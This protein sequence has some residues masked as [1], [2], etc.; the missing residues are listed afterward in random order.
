MESRLS[1]RN[2]SEVQ[3]QQ[4]S[5]AAPAPQMTLTNP[6]QTM[7]A[8]NPAIAREVAT[9]QAQMIIAQTCPRNIAVVQQ[10]IDTACSRLQLAAY[11]SYSYQR[12]GTDIN[13]PSIRLAEALLNAYGNSKAGFEI[14]AQTEK[15]STVRAYAFDMETNTLMER[16]FVVPHRRDT[17][18]GSKTLTDA[19]DIYEAVAN[20]AARRVRACILAIIPADLQEYAVQ[21]CNETVARNV[22]IT[23]DT[24]DNLLAAFS[25][26]GVSK[27]QIEAFIQRHLEA[28]TVTQYLR[29]RSMYTAL[30]DGLAKPE[31]MFA[32]IED[33][34]AIEESPVN[35]STG[36]SPVIPP[37]QPESTAE[38]KESA[39]ETK[40]MSDV[41]AEGHTGLG[42]HAEPEPDEPRGI[43]PAESAHGVYP[44]AEEV[45]DD[46]FNF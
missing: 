32:P 12:G 17:K 36:S 24:L 22:K 29:L 40:R 27:A 15:E 35:A 10:K 3:T 2:N 33:A 21:K 18:A 11:A 7:F 37:T 30:K 25:T 1:R 5:V 41:Y 26:F 19:R 4:Q 8:S 45:S 6:M 28:I 38:A 23:P 46:E 20:Q 16:T 39:P 43:T 31:E 9:V 13:G 44:T 42:P 14:T 34:P